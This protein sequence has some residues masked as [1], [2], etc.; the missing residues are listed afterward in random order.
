[1]IEYLRRDDENPHSSNDFGMNVIPSMLE[2]GCRLYA[3]PFKGYWK[4]VG[5]VET[6]W[7]ANMDLLSDEEGTDGLNLFD[8]GWMIYTYHQNHPPQ[9]IAPEARLEN[10]LVNEGCEIHG[11]VVNSIL[12]TGVYVGEGSLIKDSVIMNNARIGKNTRVER[13]I[14][15]EGVMIGEGRLVSSEEKDPQE[16]IL[17]REDVFLP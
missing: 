16:I 6:Y 8:R 15:S 7:E 11:E 17:V 4:D 14:I 1:M 2:A 10:S 13:A 9:Y 12:F 3:Y 5:T